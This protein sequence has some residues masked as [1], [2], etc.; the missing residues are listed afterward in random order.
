[1]FRLFAFLLVSALFAGAQLKERDEAPAEDQEYDLVDEDEDVIQKTD[2]A[3]NPIQA[4]KEFKVGKFYDKKGNHKAAAWRYEE[5]TRWNPSYSE[6]FLRLGMARQEL[7]HNEKA[8]KAFQKYL[9][10]EPDGKKADDVKQWVAEL[11]DRVAPKTT[12]EAASR[13]AD[14]ARR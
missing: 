12:D 3:F 14:S 11:E 8:L 1:M 13:P 9:D 2:Y 10:L 4:K 5:A 6:A 7:G